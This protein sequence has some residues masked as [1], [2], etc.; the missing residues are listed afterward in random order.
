[1]WGR[2][3]AFGI[4]CLCM[5]QFFPKFSKSGYS[6]RMSI[7]LNTTMRVTPLQLDAGFDAAVTFSLGKLGLESIAMKKE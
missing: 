6:L 7:K 1:V 3:R 5:R 2:E 4:S